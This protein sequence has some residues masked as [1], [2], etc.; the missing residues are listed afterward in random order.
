MIKETVT[1][2][3]D[4]LKSRGVVLRTTVGVSMEP[5]LHEHKT[6]VE[7]HRPDG[8]L[9]KNDMA[10]FVRKNGDIVLHRVRRVCDG[11]YLICG[12]NQTVS[13]RVEQSQIIGVVHRFFR[14]N[15]WTSVSDRRYL[16]YVHAWNALFLVRRYIMAAARRFGKR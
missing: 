7:I 8:I 3:E 11:Y 6:I 4:E 12:D 14:N 9:K 13:E 2:I 5:L 15:K 10:L 16:L 1:T